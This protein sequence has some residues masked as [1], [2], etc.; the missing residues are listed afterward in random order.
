MG[1]GERLRQAATPRTGDGNAPSAMKSA[2]GPDG[3]G[4]GGGETGKRLCQDA[5]EISAGADLAIAV[6]EG[7]VIYAVDECNVTS[8]GVTV[9]EVRRS[10][11]TLPER[12][13]T[14]AALLSL[15]NGAGT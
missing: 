4:S 5:A 10:N 7:G 9:G 8:D 3:D 6:N 1:K 12:V 14:E 11:V 13:K 2:A 15:S